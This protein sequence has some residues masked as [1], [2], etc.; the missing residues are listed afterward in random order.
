MNS[1]SLIGILLNGRYEIIEHIGTGSFSNVYQVWDHQ[2]NSPFACKCLSK[3]GLNKKQLDAQLNEIK[4]HM[5]VSDVPYVAKLQQ[6][7]HTAEF[8]Y[9]ILELNQ[10]DLF[11][12]MFYV[13]LNFDQKKLM[14]MQLL[15]AVKGL[16]DMGVYHRDLKPENILI[17]DGIP[18][19]CDFGL[20]TYYPLSSEFGFGS[21]RYMSPEGNSRGKNDPTTPYLS[22][23]NDIW[24]LAIIFVELMSG[25]DLWVDSVNDPIFI[26]LI[27]KY[28]K[29]NVD[30]FKI[31]GFSEPVVKMLRQAFDLDPFLRP[32]CSD[33]MNVLN[34]LD[35]FQESDDM[36]IVEEGFV[37]EKKVTVFDSGTGMDFE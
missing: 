1:N 16:H 35:T 3:K 32:S 21:I 37:K 33:M 36:I 5:H 22:S 9:I 26:E 15:A 17:K 30:P 19:L 10:T 8:I 27:F 20:A 25:R 12:Y 18:S 13:K 29:G 2:K 4:I 28:Q 11:D 6:V 34:N 14:F 7:I 24:A 23:A 31:F